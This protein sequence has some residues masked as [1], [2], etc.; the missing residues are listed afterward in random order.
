MVRL[1]DTISNRS[2]QLLFVCSRGVAFGQRLYWSIV[3]AIVLIAVGLKTICHND[4]SAPKYRVVAHH[5]VKHLAVNLHIRLLALDNKMGL[6]I[7]SY[8]H[9]VGTLRHTVER[10]WML[11][12]DELWGITTL[13]AQILNN[14][15]SHPLFGR[16]HQPATTHH[17]EHLGAVVG[18]TTC[19]ET[20]GR[21]VEF[22]KVRHIKK[23]SIFVG[24]DT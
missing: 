19:L 4:I 3:L 18:A 22:W 5:L 24:K 20:Y 6:G 16:E 11:L 14:V 9:D 1:L 7:S 2:I 15:T 12:D 17:I 8:N 21:K 23:N 13:C 10:Y